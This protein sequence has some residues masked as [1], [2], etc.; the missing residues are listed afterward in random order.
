MP[1]NKPVM[2]KDCIIAIIE[3]YK[4]FRFLCRDDFIKIMETGGK[5]LKRDRQSD[6]KVITSDRKR[7]RQLGASRSERQSSGT[8][9]DLEGKN[10]I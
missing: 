1:K 8:E 4:T 3:H 10:K 7:Y 9:T 5:D 2:V 6:A